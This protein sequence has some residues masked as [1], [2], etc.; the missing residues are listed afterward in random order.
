MLSDAYDVN[1][2]IDFSIN[3]MDAMIKHAQCDM[4]LT[5]RIHTRDNGEEKKEETEEQL[6]KKKAWVIFHNV[7][8]LKSMSSIRK[9]II[10]DYVQELFYVERILE[11][12]DV[13]II[14][15]DDD[16]NETVVEYVKK[17]FDKDGIYIIVHNIMRL[18]CN[19][20]KHSLVAPYVI[21]NKEEKEEFMVKYN[22]TSLAQI[23]EI[24]R[25][26]PIAMAI[27][28]RPNEVCRILRKSPTAVTYNYYRVCV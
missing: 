6:R 4:M 16:P 1:D 8:G 3:E 5:E 7:N 20:L 9:N 14:I 22:I 28:L 19:I 11:K 2:H 21:L 17:L 27:C 25:F 13:L 24:S 23:P 15:I 12:E 18:Q 26:D 10:D